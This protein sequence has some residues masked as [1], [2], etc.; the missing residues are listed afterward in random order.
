MNEIG[1]L[2]IVATPI[3]NL[4]D[5]TLRALRILKEV[6]LILCEDTR[7]TGFL[8]KHYE[9]K[10]K[11][12]S[13]HAHSTQAKES[14]IIKML[15]SGKNIA[16]VSDA[17]TPCISD[18]GMLLVSSIYKSLDKEAKVVPIPGPSALISALSASGISAANFTFLGFLPHKKGRE[19]I[20][21][22]IALNK[23]QVFIF[24]ESTHRVLKTLK[25][26]VEH[27]PNRKIVIAR[28]I[29]KKFEEFVSGNAEKLEKYLTEN[30]E[31]QK[32]EFVIIVD[33]E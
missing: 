3:G 21:K 8:L 9:I 2:Y 19:T 29:T 18:P 30:S 26:F 4:E 15:E 12:M 31:K 20:F 33:K 16:M 11:T 5:I 25:S 32:G 22:D 14:L 6:D 24:Y 17:G 13:Y 28:E 7:T 23:E 10:N 27:L 1:T